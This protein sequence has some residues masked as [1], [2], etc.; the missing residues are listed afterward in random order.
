MDYS[1]DDSL[2]D[3]NFCPSTED[4][5]DSSESDSGNEAWN[6]PAGSRR[7]STFSE[8]QLPVLPNIQRR[9]TPRSRTMP[10]DDTTNLP[11]TSG[12]TSRDISESEWVK[13]KI[14]NIEWELP[15]ADDPEPIPYTVPYSG[16]L[17]IYSGILATADPIDYFDLFLTRDI[18]EHIVDQT[19]LYAA[20]NLL[21][22]NDVGPQ[23]R[24]HSWNPVTVDEML[25]FLALIGWMGLVKLPAIKD[26]WRVH[27]LYGIP[28]ARTVMPRNRFELILKYIHFSDNTEAD[29]E[30]RLCKI[31]VVLDKFIENYK[32]MYT[33]GKDICVDES[34][35]PWRGRLIFRQYIPNKAAK[36][37]IKIFKLCTE[38]GYTWNLYVYCGKSKEKDVDVSEKTVMTLAQGLLD[39]GRTIYTD[40]YYTSIW[41]TDY[42]AVKHT[43]LVL[44]DPIENIYQKMS[45]L[46]S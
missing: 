6:P 7:I 14:E 38:K 11:S 22:D 43:L 46:Q 35:I 30:D 13:Q 45:L 29:T 3:P 39:Q 32:K 16:M 20:Q 44:S 2:D 41:H 37:G 28:L 40:N 24:A 1:S 18:V 25:K 17:D 10:S 31:R 15:T 34:L 33:P 36:Y 21:S 8:D 12:T 42:D 19:N 27:K 9:R 26:Y 23:A 5:D 4:N